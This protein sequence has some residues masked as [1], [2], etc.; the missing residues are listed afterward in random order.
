MGIVGVVP[1]IRFLVF[2]IMG[3]THGHIQ[4]L[5]LGSSLTVGAL[6]AL[7]I[8]VVA[9]LQRTNRVLIEDAL[10]RV[11]RL[12]YEPK[13]RAFQAPTTTTTVDSSGNTLSAPGEDLGPSDPH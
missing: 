2:A 6:L 11:K 4:S 3:E 10:E 5:V 12:Q 1:L 7:A 13:G 8:L 9:D